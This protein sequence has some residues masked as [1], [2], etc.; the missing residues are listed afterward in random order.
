MAYS[1]L[2]QLPERPSRIP[3]ARPRETKLV[4]ES[5]AFNS[6]LD[7]VEQVARTEATVLLLGETGTGKGL[8]ARAIHD[9][10]A[11]PRARFLSV[12]C[13][14]LPPTLLES[15]L[16]GR[17]RGAYTDASTPQAGRF[18]LAHGGTI[19]LDEIGE[20]PLAVQAKL[21]RVLQEGTVER[22]GSPRTIHV[23]V[24]VIAATNRDIHEDVQ[25]GRFRHDL[26]YRLNVFPISIPP[27]RAR[28]GDVDV[29]IP[30]LVDQLSSRYGKRIHTIHPDVVAQCRRYSWPGNIRELE[31][32]IERAIIMSTDG[33]LRLVE[34]LDSSQI[35]SM[36]SHQATRLVDVE[37]LHIQRILRSTG[38]RIEGREG[39]AVA[40]G[41]HPSTLRS[42]M[43]KLG[44]SRQVSL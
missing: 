44:I 16:F 14:S 17:E 13:A 22:L 10:S 36:D 6:I 26:F 37:R 25:Q 38:G 12:D 4:G 43:S 11:R 5:Q 31:H 30:F 18:E 3:M 24:R 2:V 42:R 23:D 40:L 32:V 21:L 1:T 19:F 8:M 28:I 39:A 34:S 35:D 29:L 15:E 41:L 27:L 33:V 20:L 7:K 9:Q